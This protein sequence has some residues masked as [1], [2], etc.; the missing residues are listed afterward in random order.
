MTS[1]TNEHMN[2]RMRA[3]IERTIHR[4]EVSAENAGHFLPS[5][6]ISK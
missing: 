1:I 5:R 2:A 3:A 6:S 4:D